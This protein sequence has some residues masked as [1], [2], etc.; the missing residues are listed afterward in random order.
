MYFIDKLYSSFVTNFTD[1]CYFRVNIFTLICKETYSFQEISNHYE[2][3]LAVKLIFSGKKLQQYYFSKNC[4]YKFPRLFKI[5]RGWSEGGGG[6]K[7][8]FFGVTYFLKGPHLYMWYRPYPN[9]GTDASTRY[10]FGYR[11]P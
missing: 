5:K 8:R 9:T 7:F 2:W 3:W 6:M 1:F 11:R 4:N 10:G